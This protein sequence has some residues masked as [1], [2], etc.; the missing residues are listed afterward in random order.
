MDPLKANVRYKYFR[1]YDPQFGR[2]VESDPIGL[3]AGVNTYAYAANLPVLNIDATGLAIWIC[4][5]KVTGF[6]FYG[7]HAYLWNANTA[8]GI[9]K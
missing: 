3:T 5:R 1:D 8:A 7:N 9:S 2:Y 4:T 6:P